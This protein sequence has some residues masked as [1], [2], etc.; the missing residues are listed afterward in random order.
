[1]GSIRDFLQ[2]GIQ[3]AGSGNKL[4][5]ELKTSSANINRLT[6]GTGFPGDET[7]IRLAKYLGE[8]PQK[9]LLL[10]QAERAPEAARPEWEKVFKKF[11]GAAVVAFVVSTALPCLTGAAGTMYIMSNAVLGILTLLIFSP[12]PADR[13]PASV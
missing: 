10:N 3:K 13:S 5:A 6:T 9:L 12:A 2:A 7:V 11:A 1:M 4:A 8:D